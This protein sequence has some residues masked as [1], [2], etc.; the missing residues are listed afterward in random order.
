[1][2]GLNWAD[3]SLI[4]IILLSSLMS[5]KRGFIKE[6]LSLATWVV[7]FIVAR[8]FHPNVQTLLVESITQPMLRT[9]AAFSILF[10]GTLLLGSA[11]NF[12]IGALVRLSGLTPIDRLLGVAFGLARGLVLSIVMIAVLR[13]TPFVNSDWWQNSVMIETLSVLEQWSRS[14][15]ENHTETKV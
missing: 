13:L 7:A 8:T 6:A 9:I 3:W 14:V 12:M 1:M 4:V 2:S 5:L 11:I 10:I 15:F